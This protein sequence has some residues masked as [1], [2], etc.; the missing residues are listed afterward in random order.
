VTL[1]VFLVIQQPFLKLETV[2][3]IVGI[4]FL[5][6]QIRALTLCLLSDDCHFKL[7]RNRNILE[8]LKLRRQ[9]QNMYKR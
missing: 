5:C 8:S 3:D 1:E 6:L 2:G 4:N 9:E 7:Y